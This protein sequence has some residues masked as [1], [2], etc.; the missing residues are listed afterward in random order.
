M[1]EV[2]ACATLNSVEEIATEQVGPPNQVCTV[3]TVW[4]LQDFSV[5]QILREIN[6]GHVEHT[7]TAILNIWAALNLKFLDIFD[8]V[9]C[10]IPKN[11]EF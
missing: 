1:T 5:T 3:S 10:E 6:F 8:F 9:K 7:K 2:T 4:K 11:L